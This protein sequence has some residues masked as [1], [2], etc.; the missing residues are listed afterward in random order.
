MRRIARWLLTMMAVAG[1]VIFICL[2]MSP[3]LEDKASSW[4]NNAVPVQARV[5][6]CT[7]HR[8]G[9]RWQTEIICQFAYAYEGQNYVAESAGWSSQDPFLTSG[10]FE[11]ALAQQS[12]MT[13]RP[14]YTRSRNPS[15]AMLLDQR[16][17]AMPPLWVWLL[18]LFV[19]LIFAM[20]R[21][22]P[23]GI[24]YRRADLAPDPS[25]GDLVPINHHRRNRVRRRLAG[26]GLS[27]LVAG[28]I[29][30]F[31][32]SNQPAN[33]V[34]KLGMTALRPQPARLV[35]CDHHY[36]RTGRSGHDQLDCDL[37]YRVDG[38][39][40]RGEADSL[41][42]GLIPTDARMDAVV[43]RLRSEPAVTAYV[44][45]R[46]PSYAWAF[47]SEDAFVPFT[48]GI[49]ELELGFL[50]FVIAAVL[51]GSVVRWFRAG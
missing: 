7:P 8:D 6:S 22:D 23:S 30:L 50:L 47:I 48:W 46:Y 21:L 26:Q 42:F 49:F 20:F 19:A 2:V 40:Y 16:W 3:R 45:R 33:I 34:A 5:T 39:T 41:R 18:I 35:N 27:A 11:R 31:G 13:T 10:E 36:Y 24:P 32:L 15:D 43:A 44:D 1:P 37:V 25:T 29:C 14:A 12:G 4:V 28:G 17:V 51:T 38:R 9:R